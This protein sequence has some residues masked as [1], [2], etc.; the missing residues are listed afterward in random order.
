M[1]FNR[2][3]LLA[4]YDHSASWVTETVGQGS[5]VSA[6]TGIIGEDLV[7]DIVAKMEFSYIMA[8]RP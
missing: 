6:I 2:T 3:S 8:I 7:V 5:Y 4:F 1:L